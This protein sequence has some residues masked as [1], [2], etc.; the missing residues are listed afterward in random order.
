[1]GKVMEKV[2]VLMSTYNGEEYLREQLESILTQDGVEVSVIVRD[3]GSTDQ[4]IS[5][6]QEYEKKGFLKFYT[7][8]NL[9]PAKSFMD[10]I[11]NAPSAKYYALCDQDDVWIQ[12][13]LKA[14]V[15]FLKICNKPALYYHGMNLVDEKLNKYDYYFRDQ[16]KAESLEFSC[17]Y[18]DEI[19][20]CTMV[21]NNQL[22]DAIREYKPAFITMHDGWIHRV[23]LCI[24]GCIY[25]DK[26]AYIN[27]RQHCNNAVGMQQRKLF[28]QFSEM[29]K[30]ECRFS[31]LAKEMLRGYEQYLNPKERKI[32]RNIC[33]YQKGIWK[34]LYLCKKSIMSTANLKLKLKCIL[35][36]MYGAL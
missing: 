2:I 15:E 24:H 5:I 16:E 36:I 32:L 31:R 27:Y 23:C 28:D 19:A 35:K 7:G 1:M 17:L 22:M 26:T 18:G 11:Y 9:K 13:K 25:G 4:T 21:F 29:R 34:T 10:L 8:E 14:A 3:D 33:D 30:K 6:L 12:G 20:G